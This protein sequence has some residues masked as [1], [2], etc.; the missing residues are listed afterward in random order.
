M[1]NET[2]HLA[3][4]WILVVL[5]LAGFIH[6]LKITDAYEARLKEATDAYEARL[7]EAKEYCVDMH[8]K[9]YYCEKI[10]D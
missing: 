1:K 8:G 2:F 4:N 10:F 9:P 7:K 5:A 6:H 3:V